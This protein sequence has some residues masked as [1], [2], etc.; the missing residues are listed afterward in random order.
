MRRGK[1][2]NRR[3]Q[4]IL[5]PVF[6]GVACLLFLIPACQS[7]RSLYEGEN[8]ARGRAYVEAE[9]QRDPMEV[10]NLLQSAQPQPMQNGTEDPYADFEQN[11]S[12]LKE[13]INTLTIRQLTQEEIAQYGQRLSG[14]QFVGDSLAQAI[15]D[16]GL[17]D[18]DHVWFRRGAVINDLGEETQNAINMLPERIVFFVGANA[19]NYYPSGQAFAE[20]CLNQCRN[21]LS[22][23]PDLR[24]YF[25]SMLPVSDELAAYREDLTTAGEYD[26][27]LR[28]MCAAN[29]IEYIDI[30]WMVRQ[31][32]YI[33][34][35]I[36]FN[37]DFYQIWLRYM[38]LYMG[39]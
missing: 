21:I 8:S 6:V 39:L 22:Q 24:L 36:H 27:A 16:Y 26:Q 28:E 30:N 38:V 35:G 4:S 12:L 17:A 11:W 13:E 25:C 33:E 9:G 15:Y 10:L 37:R 23:R 5:T 3:N 2:L 7:R 32:L 19:L 20:A 29:G 31:E 1:K 14:V 18:G 34:D